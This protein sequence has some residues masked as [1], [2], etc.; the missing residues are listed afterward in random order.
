MATE[1]TVRPATLADACALAVWELDGHE[2]ALAVKPE[3]NG[4][5]SVVVEVR[6]PS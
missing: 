5:A 3:E 1:P 6:P 4:A 2:V